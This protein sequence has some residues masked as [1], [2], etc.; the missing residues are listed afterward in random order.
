MNELKKLF[1]E[2]LGD[3]YD[4][5]KQIANE[6]KIMIKLA[7]CEKLKSLF[8]EHQLKSEGHIKS[9]ERVF[10]SFNQ[11]PYSIKCEA[12]IGLIKE[13]KELINRIKGA[14][15]IDAALIS[16]A[17]K[18]EHYEIASYGCLHEWAKLLGNRE[19]QGILEDN[20]QEEISSNE[21]L[22]LLARTCCNQDALGSTHP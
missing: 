15:A 13:S 9:L 1:L 19:S 17:Q 11:K 6:L 3:R 4:S 14:K 10:E 12:T 20:L 5:E 21:S 8:Y 18:I 2:E 7:T 16:S 22:I